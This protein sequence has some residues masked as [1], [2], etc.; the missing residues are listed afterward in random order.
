VARKPDRWRLTDKDAK[1]IR[2][3][4]REARV[5]KGITNKSIAEELGWD[6]TVVND[7]LKNG[8]PL[9]APRAAKLL[10]AV[11]Y[12]ESRANRKA[13]SEVHRLF[14][15]L[16]KA[17]WYSAF[18]DELQP[19]AVLIPE[20]EVPRLADIVADALGKGNGLHI[21]PARRKLVVRTI[22]RRLNAPLRRAMA[23][24]WLA[25]SR[26]AFE[27]AHRSAADRSA[28]PSSAGDQLLKFVSAGGELLDSVNA[29][30]RNAVFAD[31]LLNFVANL[32]APEGTKK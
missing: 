10:I 30:P 14:M 23:D 13:L 18:Q 16:L 12:H 20:E 27:A 22:R 3:F 7:V 6:V 8:R 1:S 28:V 5:L 29:A 32:A 11:Y 24:A 26:Q 21:G 9:L 17:E 31:H 2:D 4:V 25:Y 15:N 19:P